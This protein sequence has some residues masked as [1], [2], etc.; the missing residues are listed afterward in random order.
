MLNTYLHINE[1]QAQTKCLFDCYVNLASCSS[2]VIC[3]HGPPP[4]GHSQNVQKYNG[5]L[6]PFNSAI[7]PVVPWN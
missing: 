6:T 2:S 1:T 7:C 3:S 5:D 4:P